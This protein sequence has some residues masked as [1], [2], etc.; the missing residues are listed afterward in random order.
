MKNVYPDIE[1]G[2]I[3]R[4]KEDGEIFKPIC[5]DRDSALYPV[6]M[7][8]GDYG[9]AVF[10]ADGRINVE[11]EFPGVEEYIPEP[12]LIKMNG[13][14]LSDNREVRILMLDS[15]HLTHPVIAMLK[16]KTGEI[17]GPESFTKTGICLYQGEKSKLDLIKIGEKSPGHN[18]E[19]LVYKVRY[20]DPGKGCYETRVIASTAESLYPWFGK[21]CIQHESVSELK[22]LEYTGDS[23]KTAIIG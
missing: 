10:T 15:G 17:I 13:I 14:Y 22:N 9:F 7:E 2:K 11:D 21:M 1:M 12:E 3:Y 16:D 8:S 20:H 19:M 4:S 23:T 18:P 6:V 5:I